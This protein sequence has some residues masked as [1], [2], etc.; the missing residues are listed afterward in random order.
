[1]EQVMHLS[2]GA[3]QLSLLP[4]RSRLCCFGISRTQHAEGH[5]QAQAVV[6]RCA[7]R[8]GGGLGGTATAAEEQPRRCQTVSPSL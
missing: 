4:L 3:V 8:Q 6:T 2:L 7:R 1:M 5:G